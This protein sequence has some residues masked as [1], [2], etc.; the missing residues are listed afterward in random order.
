MFGKPNPESFAVGKRAMALVLGAAFLATLLA[1]DNDR[2][3]KPSQEPDARRADP[4]FEEAAEAAGV[5]FVHDSG[6]LTEYYMPEIMSGGVAMLDYDGDGALDLYFVQGGSLNTGPANGTANRLYRNHGDG[7]FED[8]TEA[9]G[10]GD[11]GYGM[12]V[13]CGDYDADGDV[14][15][16]VT[17]VGPNVLFRND[18]DGTFTNVSAQAGVNDSGWPHR[19][20][21][22]GVWPARKRFSCRGHSLHILLPGRSGTATLGCL[23]GKQGFDR[24]ARNRHQHSRSVRATVP[25]VFC[26]TCWFFLTGLPTGLVAKPIVMVYFFATL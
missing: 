18:G 3:A 4:W 12:G 9:A 8:V 21:R 23:R 22:P 13:A 11:L 16:Y 26:R 1:C 6:H 17:N 14:D 20:A 5:D 25:P 19:S 10:V 2:A 7:T 15:L 24:D